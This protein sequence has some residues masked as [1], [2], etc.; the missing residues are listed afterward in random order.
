MKKAG[1]V[2]LEPYPGVDAPWL[3][4]H[5]RCGGEVRPSL[6]NTKRGQGGCPSCA[7]KDASE[8]NR[9]PEEDA[10]QIMTQHDLTPI[11]AYKNSFSPWPSRHKC[12]NIVSPALQN[13]KI[14]KG[15]CRYCFSNFA[16][17][18]PA[19]LYLV[20]DRDAVKIGCAGRDTDRI[21][22]HERRGWVLVWTMD[23]PTGDDAYNLEQAVLNWWKNDLHLSPAYT[24]AAMPQGG[25]SETAWWD[26]ISP[27]SVLRKA[28][29]LAG[30]Y[31]LG[32]LPFRCTPFLLERPT[33]TS[34]ALGRRARSRKPSPSQLSLFD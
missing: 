24:A 13:I 14:G 12:G 31:G 23:T 28:Q 34:S 33:Q 9:M 27:G 30:E 20:A 4:Q 26:E 15:I 22:S 8:R 32:E 10:R 1:L 7:A 5:E 6:T 11:A 16:Y 19:T 25:F 29:Q 21:P 17:D 2:P 18:G 3:C